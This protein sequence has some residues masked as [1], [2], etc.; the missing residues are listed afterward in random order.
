MQNLSMTLSGSG[1]NDTP[2]MA[3]T[4]LTMDPDNDRA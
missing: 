1:L 2:A 4:R 3:L